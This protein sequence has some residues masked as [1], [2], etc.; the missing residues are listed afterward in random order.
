MHLRCDCCGG[1]Y[2]D[3][4][5]F[6]AALLFSFF[7]AVF[8]LFAVFV[9]LFP[10]VTIMLDVPLLTAMMAFKILVISR[11]TVGPIFL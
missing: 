5:N 9:F 2:I 1:D 11:F 8:L 10:C 6:D 3:L 7:L 4:L